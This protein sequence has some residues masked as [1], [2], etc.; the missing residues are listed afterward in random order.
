MNKIDHARVF[1]MVPDGP[2]EKGWLKIF[3][4]VDGESIE[5][6]REVPEWK[7]AD[8]E[9]RSNLLA[10]HMAQAMA[11]FGVFIARYGR[12]KS[13]RPKP[14]EAKPGLQLVKP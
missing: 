7:A 12:D 3:G 10:M 2:D 9:K 14:A 8:G 6:S 11:D 13:G 1:L 5:F 4:T